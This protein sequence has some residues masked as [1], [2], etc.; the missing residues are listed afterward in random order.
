[1]STRANYIFKSGRKT[2]ATFYIHHDGYPEGAAEYFHKAL[3]Y[4]NGKINSPDAFLRAND[5]CEI[6][7]IHGDIEYLY[8]FDIQTQKLKVFKVYF[9]ETGNEKSLYIVDDIYMF[10]NRYSV[11][12]SSNTKLH[13][14]RRKYPW[15]NDSEIEQI[16]KNERTWY[17]ISVQSRW[18]PE[19]KTQA[20]CLEL[21]YKELRQATEELINDSIR[22][23][24]DNP[25]YQ[26]LVVWQYNLMKQLE[27]LVDISNGKKEENNEI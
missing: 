1:M 24:I 3:I 8:V 2:L 23:G 7:C 17:Y 12:F 14:Y 11:V 9:T 20:R 27:V 22:Y 26:H 19:A 16:I 6:S 5:A 4:D 13:E 10:I 21:V 18:N 15:K 25:N